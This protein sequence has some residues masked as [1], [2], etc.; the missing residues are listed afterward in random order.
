M[1]TLGCF[2]TREDS[3][4]SRDRDA[5]CCRHSSY[6][7]KSIH[8]SMYHIYFSISCMPYTVNA[9]SNTLLLNISICINIWRLSIKYL[10]KAYVNLKTGF[11]QIKSVQIPTRVAMGNTFV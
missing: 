5:L 8:A 2:F 10:V 1:E 11:V 7:R 4:E 3:A 9:K 6:T